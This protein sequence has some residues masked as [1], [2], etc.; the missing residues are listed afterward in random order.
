MARSD[1]DTG[2]LLI[3]NKGYFDCFP[4]GHYCLASMANDS[5]NTLSIENEHSRAMTNNEALG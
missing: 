1:I 2:Y 4:T 3:T 5:R